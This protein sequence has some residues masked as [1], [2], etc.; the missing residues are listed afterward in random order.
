MFVNGKLI[1]QGEV[2]VSE[3]NFGA[4]IT[5]IISPEERVKKMGG[6]DKTN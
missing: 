5:Q 1:A 6:M 2:V 4:K 3:E